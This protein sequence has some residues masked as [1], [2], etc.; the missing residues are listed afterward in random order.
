MPMGRIL[1][2]VY[3]V[4]LMVEKLGRTFCSKATKQVLLI[5]RSIPII[6]VSCMYPSGRLNANHI[7]SLA[8]AKDAV[9]SNQ[10]M[11]AI[12]GSR[13]HANQAYRKGRW[14]KLVLLFLL[15]RKTVSGPLLMQEM[16]Q[17][18]APM[19]VERAGSG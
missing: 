1:T 9:F 10:L 19:M 16:A 6:L 8:A 17:F 18:S 12:L 2:G 14:V 15:L 7:R 5:L 11:V 4:H 13:L 3:I